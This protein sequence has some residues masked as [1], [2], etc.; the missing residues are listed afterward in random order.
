[1]SHDH[2]DHVAP[3]DP[4][5][6][7]AYG[8][9]MPGAITT[10]TTGSSEWLCQLHFGR[11]AVQWQAITAEL[12]RVAWLVDAVQAIRRY[13]GRP[14][15]WPVV[16]RNIKQAFVLN[17]R[18]DLLN[19]SSESAAAWALRLDA[20]LR[21]MAS[22]NAPMPLLQP[23]VDPGASESWKKATFEVPEPA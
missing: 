6:C 14:A 9:P 2:N 21:S 20:E 17:Q 15:I 5:S 18:A 13:S 3:R 12:N 1:M 19:A 16:Y 8:C 10:S 23:V 7:A 22:G 11:D 4:C